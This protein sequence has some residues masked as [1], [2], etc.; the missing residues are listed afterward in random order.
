MYTV[1]EGIT[2]ATH[3]LR[4]RSLELSL[5][6]LLVGCQCAHADEGRTRGLWQSGGVYVQP[7]AGE[8]DVRALTA[9]LVWPWRNWARNSGGLQFSGSW[10][11]HVLQVRSRAR[12]GGKLNTL[13][14][15]L[16]PMLRA[17]PAA[18]GQEHGFIEGGVG[19]AVSDGRYASGDRFF[20]TRF[21][22]VT[23]VGAGWVWGRSHEVSLRIA[24]ASNAGIRQ[25][26]PGENLLQ[27]RY[28]HRWGG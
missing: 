13:A 24:H 7:G 5:G 6:L 14:L 8:N 26:N 18:A 9:G 16:T 15:G 23:S 12:D 2:L 22:F 27:L 21:N 3:L 19:L 28:F 4:G 10:D 17:T 25:P 20:S 1:R 11:V